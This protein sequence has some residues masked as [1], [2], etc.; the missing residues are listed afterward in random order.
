[1]I[2]LK[3]SFKKSF[4]LYFRFLAFYFQS[5]WG[6][7]PS[8]FW[9]LTIG[10]MSAA[11]NGE[12]GSPVCRVRGMAPQLGLEAGVWAGGIRLFENGIHVPRRHLFA[13]FVADGR[14][15]SID[16]KRQITKLLRGQ[17]V[18]WVCKHARA[19]VGGH[20]EGHTGQ[21]FKGNERNIRKP[22]MPY[23][24]V[25]LEKFCLQNSLSLLLYL[26]TF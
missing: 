5:L 23:D 21:Q 10:V 22:H 26:Y 9:L 20:R 7:N 8:F 17:R 15:H 19:G 13:I 14:V 25:F 11:G 24:F 4:I 6:K 1:M 16:C 3:K 18:I 2:I 12:G